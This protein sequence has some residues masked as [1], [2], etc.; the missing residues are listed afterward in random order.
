M[1][2]SD[3][4]S[5]FRTHNKDHNRFYGITTYQSYFDRPT[6]PTP[7]EVI[8]TDGAKMKTLSGW[9]KPRTQEQTGPKIV[10]GLVGEVYKDRKRF[11]LV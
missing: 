9:N 3:F 4:G 11:L 10:G 5:T 2:P 1:Y 6:K 7:E 8:R